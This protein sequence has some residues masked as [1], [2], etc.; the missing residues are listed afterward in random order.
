[1]SDFFNSIYCGENLEFL[2]AVIINLYLN[3]QLNLLIQVKKYKT[4]PTED[5]CNYII[6]RFILPDSPDQINIPEDNV[7]EIKSAKYSENIFNKACDYVKNLVI[8]DNWQKYL[9]SSQFR[10]WLK[11]KYPNCRVDDSSRSGEQSDSSGKK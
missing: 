2:I 11:S 4:D 5:C 3:Q 7:I 10:F 9:G 1:M 6:N 8:L